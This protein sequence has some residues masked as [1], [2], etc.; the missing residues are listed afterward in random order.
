VTTQLNNVTTKFNNYKDQMQKE[1]GR[2]GGLR[3]TVD[4][5]TGI[6]IEVRRDFALDL[7]T[8]PQFVA[9]AVPL[10]NVLRNAVIDFGLIFVYSLL[11]FAGRFV[12]FQRYDVR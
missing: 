8:V 7:S 2:R 4:S 11:A 9:A 10:M 1:S 12:A 5:Q 3:I 6:K